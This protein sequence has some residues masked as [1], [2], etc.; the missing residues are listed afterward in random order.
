[1]THTKTL[2]RTLALCAALAVPAAYAKE[3]PV[4]HTQAT[5]APTQQA[6][7]YTTT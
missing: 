6:A 1:M 7:G 5:A 4:A 2:F 3:A